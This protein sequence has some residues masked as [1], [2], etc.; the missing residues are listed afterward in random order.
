[1]S[2][3]EIAF[4]DKSIKTDQFF[5]SKITGIIQRSVSK[6][7][8]LFTNFLTS[9]ELETA[10]EMTKNNPQVVFYGGHINTKR[11]IMGAFPE[12]IY[13]CGFGLENISDQDEFSDEA[14]SFLQDN[15]PIDILKVTFNKKFGEKLSHSD[16][17]GSLMG[18][19]IKRET[20]GDIIID[21]E[22]GQ[23]YLFVLSS[24]SSYIISEF[25]MV[26]RQAV[27]VQKSDGDDILIKQEYDEIKGFISSLRLDCVVAILCN[28]SR[29]KSQDMITQMLVLV[30][31]KQVVKPDFV[32]KENDV[33]VIKKHGKFILQNIHMTK[34]ERFLMNILK[35][36]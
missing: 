6:N 29:T 3:K 27:T 12:Y 32:I 16:F 11:K 10:M 26:G 24:V 25:V 18:L 35:Y 9:S 22:A 23:A 7:T 21:N 8:P 17:L 36:K 4:S 28:K 31:G 34:R 20:V 14:F 13:T 19:S 15:F 1:M 5:K 33:L 30:N 2:D